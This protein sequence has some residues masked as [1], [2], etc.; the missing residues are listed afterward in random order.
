M[1]IPKNKQGLTRKQKAFADELIANPKQSATK[2]AQN[3]YNLKDSKVAAV[4]ASENLRKPNIVAYLEQFDNFA[5]ETIIDVA[6]NSR[7]LKDEPAHANIA[8]QASKD[9]L[10]RLHGKATQ[11]TESTSTVVTLGLNLSDITPN[12]KT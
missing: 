12:P 1:P 6:Q 11:R 4:V 9:I 10:D 5:Q 3:T 8:L 2:S 7:T